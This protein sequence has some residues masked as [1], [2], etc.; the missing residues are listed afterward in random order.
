MYQEAFYPIIMDII[1]ILGFGITIKHFIL[2]IPIIHISMNL[3]FLVYPRLPDM[4][5]GLRPQSLRLQ[6]P[7]PLRR[8][9]LKTAAMAA[10]F[11]VVLMDRNGFHILSNSRCF[12][13]FPWFRE[14]RWFPT[15]SIMCKSPVFYSS[16]Q[17]GA[18]SRT[19]NLLDL[20]FHENAF[21][22]VCAQDFCIALSIYH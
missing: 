10:E 17:I 3:S 1:L 4:N 11:P 13:Q 22:Q 5:F 20:F 7:L 19:R 15:F 8:L 18:S 12:R 6:R 21:L 2:T 14:F 9:F 16:N